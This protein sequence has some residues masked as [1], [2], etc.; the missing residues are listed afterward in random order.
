MARIDKYRSISVSSEI[1]VAPKEGPVHISKGSHKRCQQQNKNNYFPFSSI[2]SFVVL[3][4]W[5]EM[6]K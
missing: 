1:F 2:P 6:E 4:R 3:F 5:G